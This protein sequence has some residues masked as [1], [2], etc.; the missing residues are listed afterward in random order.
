M[1]ITQMRLGKD[2]YAHY[3]VASDGRSEMNEYSG[4]RPLSRVLL[5]LTLPSTAV[6]CAPVLNSD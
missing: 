5:S 4:L 6:H 2:Q 1:F 3:H